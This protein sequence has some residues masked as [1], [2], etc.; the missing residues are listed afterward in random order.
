MDFLLLLSHQRRVVL[1][2]DGQQHYSVDG[3]PS[4]QRDAEMVAEAR[5]IRLEG[6][7]VYRFGG[8]EFTQPR[9]E[10]S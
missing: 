3:K 10:H 5:R 9:A 7:E 8:W 6:F 1:E 4:P 2:V